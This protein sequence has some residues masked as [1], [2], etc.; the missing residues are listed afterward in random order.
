M[1]PFRLRTGANKAWEGGSVR[2]SISDRLGKT[3]IRNSDPMTT[4]AIE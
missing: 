1:D 4:V 2:P 3:E